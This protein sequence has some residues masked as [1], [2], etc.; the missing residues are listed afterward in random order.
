MCQHAPALC[1]SA[2]L[3]V[4]RLPRRMLSCI[5]PNKLASGCLHCF[6]PL[7][8]LTLK[9]QPRP[10][11]PTGPRPPFSKQCH[12]RQPCPKPALAKL[13]EPLSFSPSPPQAQ[14]PPA[15]LL[16]GIL[17]MASH[18]TVC[19]LHSWQ[20]TVLMNAS[21][22]QHI[23]RLQR[24]QCRRV[25]LRVSKTSVMPSLKPSGLQQVVPH[26]AK[27]ALHPT[28][29]ACATSY[30]AAKGAGSTAAPAAPNS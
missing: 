28:P 12:V 24:G 18:N 4:T 2:V 16:V 8:L 20:D 27:L 1:S 6:E 14:A 21:S 15:P 7:L 19:L 30:D 10:A 13:A 3:E 9:K 26:F 17:P 29:R 5:S 11:P 23:C 25:P 22:Q